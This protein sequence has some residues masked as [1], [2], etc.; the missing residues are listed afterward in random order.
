MSD[1]PFYYFI[2][3]NTND[4]LYQPYWVMKKDKLDGKEVFIASYSNMR[5]AEDRLKELKQYEQ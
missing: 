4:V 2:K 5:E 1:C 3:H